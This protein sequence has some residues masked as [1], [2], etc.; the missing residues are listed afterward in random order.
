MKMEIRLADA[1]D[2]P[3]LTV[4]YNQAI[5][6]GNAT[7]H[8][9]PVS[10]AERRDWL[11]DHRPEDHHPV[12]VALNDNNVTGYCSLSA[13][14][15]GRQALR[16][17][18]EVSYFV[19][20]QWRSRGIATALLQY[21]IRQCPQLEIH[22]LFAILLDNNPASAGLLEK[23]GFE[24]WGHLPDVARFADKRVGHWYYGLQLAGR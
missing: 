6:L 4:I 18:K 14:R 17:T 2:V 21:A 16:H 23:L 12:Y 10:E 7:A 1:A 9:A 24:C 20:E 19:H 15:P 5:A 3:A 13:Y 8:T 11:A 22:T